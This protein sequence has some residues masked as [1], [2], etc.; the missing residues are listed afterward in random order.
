MWQ[1]ISYYTVCLSLFFPNYFLIFFVLSNHT[2][3][4]S[5]IFPST[6]SN[7]VNLFFPR[8]LYSCLCSSQ[9]HCLLAFASKAYSPLAFFLSKHTVYL[10]MFFPS[11][12]STCL[13]S[14]QTFG[15]LVFAF[16]IYTPLFF[17]LSK[18]TLYIS[19][20]FP[21]TVPYKPMQ[22]KI[23]WQ[24]RTNLKKMQI[25]MALRQSNN[26]PSCTVNAFKYSLELTSYMWKIWA[27]TFFFI[28]QLA[29]LLLLSMR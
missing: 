20:F 28:S 14:F 16:R 8:T 27:S 18:L 4:L 24:W 21:S 25:N 12:P 10:S 6:L 9:A 7:D 17:V 15:L 26:F 29:T 11:T 2:V 19:F 1:I 3:Y 23:S 13:L 5:L 22:H